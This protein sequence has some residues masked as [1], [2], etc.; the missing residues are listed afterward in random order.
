VKLEQA[1]YQLSGSSCDSQR[2]TMVLTC[3]LIMS[4]HC[5]G[6]LEFVLLKHV[7]HHQL[8]QTKF[9]QILLC[10]IKRQDTDETLVNI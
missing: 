10:C 4:L 8:L 1:L 7:A 2:H 3:P 9:G 5:F 6:H